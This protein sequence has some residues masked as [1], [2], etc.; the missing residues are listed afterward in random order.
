MLKSP[1]YPTWG[2]FLKRHRKVR[3]RSARE[4][5]AGKD[6]GISYPQYSRYE[7]GEQLPSL[8][9][10]IEIYRHLDIP[11]LEGVLEWT[12]AQAPGAAVREELE[13]L[14][15]RIRGGEGLKDVPASVPVPT[16]G[17]TRTPRIS[18]DE[19]IVFNRSHL[20]LFMSDARYRDIFTLV[21]SFSP[22]P[23]EIGEVAESL[24]LTHERTRE[25]TMNLVNLGVIEMED[26][27]CR[28]SKRTFYF[29]DDPDFFE[30]R[31]LNLTHN[32]SAILSK[33]Q[34]SHLSD[35]RAYRGLITR[36]LTAPQLEQVIARMEELISTVAHM[37][38]TDHPE[39]IYSICLLAGQRFTREAAKVA[40]KPGLTVK[41]GGTAA[42][43]DSAT[44]TA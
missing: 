19:V 35:R 37:P 25:M 36:E 1:R 43:L 10:A 39:R 12:R 27:K 29:P 38:E 34:H 7:S 41:R 26:G 9:Q 30:L 24:G 6:I 11:A 4:F 17:P 13:G 5:C 23:L 18:L 31:N 32:A 2:D 20:R 14:I 16:E 8:E 28:S 42:K 15:A 33:L 3:F 40:Q 44:N 22:R 21:N